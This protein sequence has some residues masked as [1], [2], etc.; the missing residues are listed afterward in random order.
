MMKAGTANLVADRSHSCSVSVHCCW[1]LQA[2]I[3]SGCLVYF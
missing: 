2:V 1:H 3:F